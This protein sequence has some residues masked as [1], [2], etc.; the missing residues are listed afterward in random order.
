MEGIKLGEGRGTSTDGVQGRRPG[1]VSDLAG[2]SPDPQGEEGLPGHQPSGGDVEGSGGDSKSPFHSL[3]HL[4]RRPSW[5]QDRSR[6][7]YRHPRG[8]AVTT[9]C[10][11]EG[12]GP[13]RDL[14]GTDQ[15][16]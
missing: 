14:P 9:A 2:S 6:H 15:G 12:G 11:L 8:Q 5:F 1:G 4:T 13:V 7:G 16:V 10:A 3:Y